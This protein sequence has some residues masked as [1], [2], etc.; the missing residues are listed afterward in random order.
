MSSQMIIQAIQACVPLLC[1]FRAQKGEVELEA[2]LGQFVQAASGKIHF[3]PGVDSTFFFKVLDMLN[4]YP[5]WKNQDS[6]A[7]VD[8]IDFHYGNLRG[9]TRDGQDMLFIEK[10]PLKCVNV[11]CGEHRYDLRVSTKREKPMDEIKMVAEAPTR[12]RVKRRMSF[13][14]RRSKND[15]VSHL[16]ELTI[17]KSG[18]NKWDAI[19]NPISTTYEVEVEVVHSVP[20]LVDVANDINLAGSLLEKMVDIVTLFQRDRPYSLTVL[21]TEQMCGKTVPQALLD[22]LALFRTY[23]KI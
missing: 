14:Y 21:Q 6:R 5:D 20:Y 19:N 18:L 8:T 12:V 7:W 11:V 15:P 3:E 9:T 10:T 22:K 13:Q 16:F 2:R 23:A 1:E 17:V 4:Q